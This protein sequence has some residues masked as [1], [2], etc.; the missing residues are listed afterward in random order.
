MKKSLMTRLLSFVL[1]VAMI[2]TL[3]PFSAI[4]AEVA[5]DGNDV[6]V[7]DGETN[8]PDDGGEEEEEE[9]VIDYSDPVSV[10]SADELET[11]LTEGASAICIDADFELDRTFYVVS[12]TVIVA[13]SPRT[14]TRAVGFGGDI[15]VIGENTDGTATLE[16][17]VFT[18]GK[19]DETTPSMITIDGNAQNM[20]T[21]VVGTVIFV[22]GGSRADLYH[23]VTITNNNKVGNEKTLNEDYNLSYP[24]RIGGAVAIVSHKGEMRIMGGTYTNNRVNDITDSSTD[25]GNL[26]SQ[27]GVIYNYGKLDVYGGTFEGNHAGRAGVFYN[28]RTLNLY[29]AEIKGNSASSLGGAIYVPNSTAAYLYIGE[30]NDLVEPDARFVENVSAN[31]A[32]AIYVQHVAIIKNA[33]FLRNVAQGDDG[34]AITAGAM[35]LTVENCLFEENVSESTYG[36]AIY[37]SGNNGD[38][39]VLELVVNDTVFK[40]NSSVRGGAVYLSGAARAFFSNAEF[41]GNTSTSHGGAVYATNATVEINGATL[42]NNTSGTNGGAI[43]LYTSAVAVINNVTAEG[44]SAALGGFAYVNGS[45]LD[46]FNSTVTANTATDNGGAIYAYTDAVFNAYNTVFSKNTA[47]GIPILQHLESIQSVIYP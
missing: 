25:E 16:P 35:E 46:L 36:G 11:A 39:D 21:D 43:G 38:E 27:G 3:F 45:S 18:L 41:T 33:T 15:F 4:A 44:N 26:S 14:L 22:R 28:Y 6:T 31:S 5:E 24:I 19:P 1:F 17:V 10:S 29:S 42:Q 9:T 37:L 2:V 23:N 8:E 40:N 13:D 32:G 12:D 7:E 34:G 47:N 20:Q 30:E